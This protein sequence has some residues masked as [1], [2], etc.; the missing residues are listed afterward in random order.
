MAWSNVG[1]AAGVHEVSKWTVPNRSPAGCWCCWANGLAVNANANRMVTRCVRDIGAS[2]FE[3]KGLIITPGC[4]LGAGADDF[5][6]SDRCLRINPVGVGRLLAVGIPVGRARDSAGRIS[7]RG[8]HG[9][10]I[11]CV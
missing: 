9:L 6:H 4:I 11:R 10:G 2:L 7:T 1:C 3:V 8:G 5:S